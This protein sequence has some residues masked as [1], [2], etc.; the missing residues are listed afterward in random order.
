MEIVQPP[1]IE[2]WTRQEVAKFL[3]VTT[4]TVQR[5][6]HEGRLTEYRNGNIVRYDQAEV[7]NL[8]QPV[9]PSA[10]EEQA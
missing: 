10:V 6:G 8:L 9:A 4:R 7:R 2:F 5:M 3:R 1:E